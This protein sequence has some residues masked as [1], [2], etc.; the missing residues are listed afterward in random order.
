MTKK[1]YEL[2]AT[3]FAGC[4]PVDG[5]VNSASRM[6]TW[7]TAVTNMAWALKDKNPRFDFRKFVNACGIK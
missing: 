5:T 2:I 7:D 1:D 3:V 6:Q 4:K